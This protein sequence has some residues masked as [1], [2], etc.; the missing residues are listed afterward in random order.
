MRKDAAKH[1]HSCHVCQVNK[2]LQQAPAGQMLATDVQEPWQM[3]SI[4]LVG[5]Q[6]VSHRRNVW[7][8]VMQDRLSNWV[9]LAALRKVTSANVAA[10]VR[11]H[12]ILRYGCPETI[13][14]DNGRQ[15]VS[16]HFCEFLKD[17]GIQHRKPHPPT[18]P[19]ATQ[20]RERIG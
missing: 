9:E 16:Q 14:S 1:V 15:F 6:P 13:T 5:P 2:A 17:C 11:Q 12:I 10:K 3:L 8:L 20:S 18:L 4:D 7:L 19:I